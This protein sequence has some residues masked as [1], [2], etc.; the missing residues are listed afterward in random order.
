MS[1]PV[2]AIAIVVA[3]ASLLAGFAPGFLAARLDERILSD[4]TGLASGLLLSSAFLL[5]MP[6][7]FHVAAEAA[8]G[9]ESFV[10]SPVILGMTVLAG[11]MVML[12][13]EGLGFGHA[14]HEE[15]HGHPDEHG[16]GH[17][18]HPNSVSLLALGLSVH[19]A[20]DGVAIG[21]AAVAGEAAFTVLVAIAV[22]IHRVPAALSLG[23]FAVHEKEV[24][25]NAA[26]GIVAFALA[27]PVAILVSYVLLGGASPRA[28]ALALLFA[29]GTFLYVATVDTLPSIHNPE[30]GARSLVAVLVG[31]ATLC[32]IFLLVN[33][34]GW[35]DHAH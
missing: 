29:A 31:A 30:V 7:G 18:H 14:V 2:I 4:V 35:L 21:A 1:V 22:L 27:T 19:A 8:D 11:F 5:V 25:A 32:A 16:H 9:A 23:L 28:T 24:W 17:V 15:H 33:Q 13:L 3:V 26:R 34:L 6:E 20:A 12:V 10:F